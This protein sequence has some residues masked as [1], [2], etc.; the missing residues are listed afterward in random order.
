ML[1]IIK[2]I[3]LSIERYGQYKKTLRELESLSDKELN[4]IGLNRGMI[5]SIAMEIY[6]D[7]LQ[8]NSNLRGWV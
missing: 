7:D 8:A 3:H 4:D 1:N 2:K 6:Y 5:K